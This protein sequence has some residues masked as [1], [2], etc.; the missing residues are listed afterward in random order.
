MD[1]ANG[2]M[3]RSIF[4]SAHNAVVLES[5]NEEGTVFTEQFLR[6]PAQVKTSTITPTLLNIKNSSSSDLVQFVLNKAQQDTYPA[7]SEVEN[8]LAFPLLIERTKASVPMFSRKRKIHQVVELDASLPDEPGK[9]LAV[10]N[11]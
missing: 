3:L 7:D 2:M 11:P 9:R 5:Q 8:C 10:G 6:L 4:K 1:S